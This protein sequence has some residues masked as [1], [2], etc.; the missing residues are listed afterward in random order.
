[1]AKLNRSIITEQVQVTA[2]QLLGK[3]RKLIEEGA[4]REI[5]IKNKTGR[6][7]LK[8]PLTEGMAVGAIAAVCAPVLSVVA[9]VALL[10]T[11]HTIEIKTKKVT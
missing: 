10:A 1:M 2:D 3:A 11:D 6:I 9:S 7:K 8:L 4:A 5:T